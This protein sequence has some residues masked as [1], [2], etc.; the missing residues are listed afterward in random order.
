MNDEA[1]ILAQEIDV[2]PATAEQKFRLRRYLPLVF[3]NGLRLEEIIINGLFVDGLD[4][5]TL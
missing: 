2:S 5:R 3:L 4:F 1:V